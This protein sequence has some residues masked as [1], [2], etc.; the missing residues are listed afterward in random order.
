MFT[1]L[2]FYLGIFV[3]PA[4]VSTFQS[5]LLD[6]TPEDESQSQAGGQVDFVSVLKQLGLT[7]LLPLLV[8]Q[9]IQWAF[10]NVVAKIK[11]KCRLSDVSSV[12]LLFMVWS[13]FSDA[14]HSGSFGVIGGV[15]I[16]AVAI[17]NAGFYILFSTLCMVLAR[18]PLPR[19]INTPTWVK[20]L[21]YSR[22]DTVAVM[23]CDKDI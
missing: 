1:P 3:S 23:V 6:A 19:F 4:L 5:P 11:V 2:S 8:G 20:R 16:V 7:V 10:P 14:V 18:L 12:M 13:V 15:D 22:E 17:I 9:L 21:R